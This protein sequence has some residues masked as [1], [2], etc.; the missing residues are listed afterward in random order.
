MDL[1]GPL[2]LTPKG[3][4]YILTIVDYFTKWV[5]AVAIPQKDAVTVAKALHEHVYCR[6]GA[7]HRVITD[8]GREFSNQVEYTDLYIKNISSH[9]L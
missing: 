1:I 6:N 9:V 2:K 3:N 4:R 7:P 8:N 5:E